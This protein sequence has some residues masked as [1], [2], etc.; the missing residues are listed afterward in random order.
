MSHNHTRVIWVAIAAAFMALVAWSIQEDDKFSCDPA[1]H[2]VLPGEGL[3]GIAVKYCDGNIQGAVRHI[4]QF[5]GITNLGD[6]RVNQLIVIPE[7]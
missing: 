2:Q 1:S 5:N 3:F 7:S 6:L 4:G